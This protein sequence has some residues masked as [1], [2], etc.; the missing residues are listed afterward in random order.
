MKYLCNHGGPFSPLNVL[1]L[2]FPFSFPIFAFSMSTCHTVSLLNQPTNFN[3]HWWQEML[4]W[5]SSITVIYPFPTVS[6]DKC[7]W[8]VESC[9]SEFLRNPYVDLH[10]LHLLPDFIMLSWHGKCNEMMQ[11]PKIYEANHFGYD[12]RVGQR[13]VAFSALVYM[14]QNF[15]Y[16][17]LT[18]VGVIYLFSV[19]T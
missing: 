4:E 13:F 12:E 2:F 11:Q 14:L 10:K 8:G 5:P 16:M 3:Q 15:W 17:Q 9:C 6:S 18:P 1:E 7:S 19:V